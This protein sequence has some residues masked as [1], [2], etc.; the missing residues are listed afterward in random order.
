MESM[1][2]AGAFAGW[3]PDLRAGEALGGR[4]SL[5]LSLSPPSPPVSPMGDAVCDGLW[6][7]GEGR[8]LGADAVT[9]R[10]GLEWPGALL[11]TSR[12]ALSRCVP[13]DWWKML[14]KAM[15]LALTATPL[16]G[17]GTSLGPRS[18]YPPALAPG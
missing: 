1:L 17:G 15:P 4:A 7:L 10:W 3:G 13:W 8:C 6:W 5:T 2:Q 14:R 12:S 9:G 18:T 11:Q 16:S